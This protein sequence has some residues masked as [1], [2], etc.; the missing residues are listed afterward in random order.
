MKIGGVE[1]TPEEIR[2]TFENHGLRIE[3]YLVKP[4]APLSNVWVAVPAIGLLFVVISQVLFAPM[5][6][7]AVL[8]HF[9]GGAGLLL[10]LALSVQ[11]RF[12]SSWA[13]GV[14]AIGGVLILSVAAGYVQPKDAAEI[15]K[16]VAR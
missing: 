1:G 5:E 15:V 4:E 13:V 16:S 14:V 10:W 3:D 6:H 7:K 8:L 9:L 12:K 2:N 11:L